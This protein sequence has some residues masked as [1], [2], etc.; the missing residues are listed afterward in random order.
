MRSGL[1]RREVV[2][3]AKTME[4]KFVFSGP[5]IGGA[6][7]GIDFDPSDRNRGGVLR[8]WFH[9]MAPILRDRYGTGGDL[10]VDEVLDVI[11][12]C[13]EIGLAHPQEG[14]VRGHL[15]AAEGELPAIFRSLDQGLKASTE[16]V[17]GIDLSIADLITGFGLARSIIHLFERQGR[18]ARGARILVEGFG[19]V[20]GPCAL[21]LSRAGAKIVGIT[22]HQNALVRPAGLSSEETEELLRLRRAK[23][24]PP[25]FPGVQPGREAFSAI[26][27]DVFVAAA[28]SET[29]DLERMNM[30]RRQGVETI[31]CGA[32]QAF[33]EL[34]LGSTG[35]QRLADQTFTVIPDVVANCG[36]A[37]TF[38]F[39][40]ENP[41]P[42]DPAVVFEAVDRTI[43][44]ALEE[45]TARNGPGRTGL[46]AS[47]LEYALDRI[48]PH[49][50]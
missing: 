24:L 38:S 47:T 1:I 29:V 49:Q 14:I 10:N 33:R 45:I 8:R 20:G 31:A 3:L 2:Y 34:K 22:D 32:N 18:S 39:L 44:S 5:N 36:M 17:P 41:S 43:S 40:M 15:R 46:L 26:Q 30:L 11:P 4:L 19:S 28:A 27:A 12:C 7:S 23:C 9:A 16:Q 37:R 21:Y 13:G 6:K 50:P 48:D 42:P 25:G 35:V